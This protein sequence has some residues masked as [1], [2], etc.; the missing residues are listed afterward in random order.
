MADTKPIGSWMDVFWDY[1]AP[2]GI[3]PEKLREHTVCV[4]EALHYHWDLGRNLILL[5]APHDRGMDLLIVPHYWIMDFSKSAGEKTILVGGNHISVYDVLSGPNMISHAL[6][7]AMGKALGAKLEHLHLPFYPEEDLGRELISALVRRYSITLV[8]ERSVALFD[9]V[10]FSL[11]TPLEQVTQLNSLSYSMN[12]AHSTLLERNI[13]IEFSRTTTG[14]G[15]Y[16][17]NKA[18]HIQA[19]VDLFYFMQLI[20]ADNAV[21]QRK[22]KGNAVPRLRSCIHAGSHYEYYQAVGLNPSTF[23]YIVGD[24]TIELARMIEHSKPNQVL[25]G[26]FNSQMTNDKTGG[27][28]WIDSAEFIRRAQDTLEGVVLADDM[29][30]SIKCYLTG[31]KRDDGSF[32]I[33]RY[34]VTDKHGRT[35]TVFNAK[36]NI[37]LQREA[38]LYLGIQ[39]IKLDEFGAVVGVVSDKKK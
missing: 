20:L 13:V 21:A 11:L 26:D 1:P 24:V 5:W 31:R 10:G 32:T 16:I 7:G 6:I 12:K 4:D 8:H 18:T 25:V 3:S 2:A 34:H 29:V 33:T 27:R 38:P 36:I 35:R 22:S 15:F 39:E 9:I 14:D 28:E 37:H 23:S 19:N 30:E 17:W